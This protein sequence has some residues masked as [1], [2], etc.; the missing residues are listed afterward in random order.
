MP[1]KI[2]RPF[3]ALLAAGLILRLSLIFTNPLYPAQGSLPGYN[4]EPLHLEYV[5]FLSQWNRLPVWF[6]EESVVN[7]LVDEFSQNP[8][9]YILAVPFFR[10]GELF[11]AGAGLYGV[12]LLSTG[13]GL[14]FGLLVY[15][16]ALRLWSSEQAALAALASALF[17]PNALLITSLVTNDAGLLCLSAAAFYSLL[18][19]RDGIGGTLRQGITGIYFG[20]AF[21]MKASAL[22]I[23]P[24]ALL[25]ANSD[26][27]SSGGER[28]LSRWRTAIVAIAVAVPVVVWQF[29]NYGWLF[30]DNPRYAPEAASGVVGGATAHPIAAAKAFLRYAAQPWD[31]LWG[32]GIEQIF[33]FVWLLGAITLLIVGAMFLWTRKERLILAAPIGLTLAAFIAH[34]IALFQV[35]FRLL[36][37]AFLPLALIVGAGATR[38]KIP[39]AVQALFW[40]GP[41]LA[42]PFLQ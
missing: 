21:W 32:K 25:A 11:G 37:P 28:W 34:N 22:A 30:P 4:D 12:R 3:L 8:L 41:I 10:L 9:Y 17:S 29:A 27:A 13:L 1:R 35:E 15:W 18:L 31:A 39:L 6:A 24:A 19:V 20:F 36:I 40:S 7:P 5:K 26:P 38:L 2:S 42:A 33:S 23:F 16:S 14:M